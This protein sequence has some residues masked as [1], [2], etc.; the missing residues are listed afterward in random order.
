L[1]PHSD[2][3]LLYNDSVERDSLL[4]TRD[5]LID[6]LRRN[7]MK[8][9]VYNIDHDRKLFIPPYEWWNEDVVKWC[10]DEGIE[11][12]SFTP[13]T[14][15]NADYTY[16][17]MGESYKSSRDI[18]QTLFQKNLNG[19]IILVHA[20]TDP[21]R[22]DKLYIRLPEIIEKLRTDGYNFVRIDELV[23]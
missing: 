21:R 20:G 16:Q 18:L 11:V 7:Y 6:D 1:G 10:N 22:K 3:H 9:S 14:G 15:T 5:S 2:Q 12:V 19:S 4:V 23:K 13:G 17:G 8:M